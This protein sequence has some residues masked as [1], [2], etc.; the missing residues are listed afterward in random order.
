MICGVRELETICKEHSKCFGNKAANLSYM[1]F[2]SFN[3]LPGFCITFD[4][5]EEYNAQIKRLKKSIDKAYEKLLQ[6]SNNSVVIVRSSADIEDSENILFPGIF[7]SKKHVLNIDELYRAIKECVYSA[8]V[9]RVKSYIDAHGKSLKIKYFT[10]IVQEELDAEYSG[11]IFSQIPWQ[12]Y[13]NDTMLSQVVQY[14]NYEF[15][16][17]LCN[18]NTYALTQKKT[19]HYRCIEKRFDINCVKE[20]KILHELYSVVLGIKDIFSYNIDIEW[21]YKDEQIYIFQARH[22][23]KPIP[24][25]L[26]THTRKINAFGGLSEQGLKYQS[27]QFFRTNK[28]FPKPVLF[29]RKET[30][31]SQ[32]SNSIKQS[33]FKGPITVRYSSNRDVGLPRAFLDSPSDA[34]KYIA[35]TKNDNWSVIVY[36]SVDI[37]D[38]YELYLD[39]NKIILEHVPGMWESDSILMTDTIVIENDNIYIWGVKD[40]RVVKYENFLGYH[41]E[42]NSPPTLTGMLKNLIHIFPILENLQDLFENSEDLPINIHFV[43]DNE[44]E[45]FLNCRVT[46]Q[47]E[48]DINQENSL[49]IVSDISDFS[50]WDGK[51]SILFRPR[52]HRGEEQFL[53]EFVPFLRKVDVPIFIEF[54]MLSH[55]AIVLREFGIPIIP[56]FLFHNY[57]KITKKELFN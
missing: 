47:I 14:D 21:G 53:W 5:N 48:F 45:Y 36:E 34:A 39:H 46:P 28:L 42:N 11:V 20:R 31:V 50:Q 33:F 40:T 23:E 4:L 22:L 17:G 15:T 26:S 19:F 41:T 1:L 54:G 18:A 37:L 30:R 8:Y 38:S 43:S 2:R 35:E 56:T 52:I 9:P 13:C 51:T 29:F 16:K 49:Y 3:V 32:I 25:H 10:V 12:G 57:Y 44:N 7:K 24:H 27:M 6:T 55:P